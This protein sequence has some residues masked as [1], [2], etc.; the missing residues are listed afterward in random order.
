MGDLAAS[1]GYYISAAA[2]SIFAMPTTLT[3]SIG[4]FGMMFNVGDGLKDKL[5]VTFDAEKNAPLADFPTASRALTAQESAR[6]QA[7]IDTIYTTF[8]SRVAVGRKITPVM[9][10][11]IAQ[12]RVW[13]GSDAMGIGLVDGLG[14]LDRALRSAAAKAKLS[15]YSVVTYPEPVDQFKSMI[16]KLRG[17]PLSSASLNEMIKAELK[18]KFTVYQQ[19][20][21]MQRISG[22]AQMVMPFK[23]EFD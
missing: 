14:G 7:T 6:M 22:K 4:V 18:E 10:D 16:R 3:G 9:V 13:S 19:L 15:A 2:D 12:G 21:W 20:E 5:G 23:P 17:N 1:G 11:S 8:K